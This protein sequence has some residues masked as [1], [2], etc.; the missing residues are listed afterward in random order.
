[1]KT[2]FSK[3]SFTVIV[4][5]ALVFGGCK[6]DREGTTDSYCTSGK[7]WAAIDD[8]KVSS[9]LK[10]KFLTPHGIINV[11]SSEYNSSGKTVIIPFSTTDD[12][13]NS[14]LTTQVITDEFFTKNVG[15]VSDFF[16]ENSWGQ[17]QL[18]NAGISTTAILNKAF[19]EYKYTE[20]DWYL[21]RD[22]CQHSSI[23]WESLD[24]NH[25][26]KITHNEVQVVFIHSHGGSGSTRT[27][28]NVFDQAEYSNLPNYVSVIYKDRQY[29][30]SNAF[31]MVDCK[32]D[33]DPTKA[34]QTLSYNTS[35]ICH[36]LG[37]G[38]FSLPDRYKVY[39]GSGG[40]G[41]YDLMSDN[42]SMK[43]LSV[44]DKLEIGWIVP[45]IIMSS[46]DEENNL[47]LGQCM[48]L[49]AIEQTPAAII[50]YNS[51]TP[52]GF[53]II[54]NRDKNSSQYNFESSLPDVGIAVWW[55]NIT[56][57]DLHLVDASALAAKPSSYENQGANAL[58]KYDP[59]K[60]SPQP[61]FFLD[62][63]GA[64][65]FSLTGITPPGKTMNFS[66]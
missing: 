19:T 1:M 5:S 38:L 7:S 43:H 60:S 61:H 29:D 34:T 62:N 33:S 37:H 28:I 32:K 36:E 17:Y 23:N 40:S 52:E 14:A 47:V 8:S 54:A 3:R 58:F 45:K 57:G 64:L 65:A 51:K 15:S 50:R 26:H 63:N 21:M 16:Y 11:N 30:I 48:N 18:T 20:S 56:T 27:P 4:L 12:P 6:P 41:Q 22:I 10:T 35:T 39:C 53:W 49:P 42:C 25:D 2:K 59:N 24:A 66:F 55:V 44:Y 13:V 31:V 9:N 46:D